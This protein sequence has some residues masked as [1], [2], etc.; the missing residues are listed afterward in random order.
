MLPM[1]RSYN[2]QSWPHSWWGC[3]GSK[4]WPCVFS[5]IV[6]LS[7]ELLCF[8][9]GSPCFL[10]CLFNFTCLAIDASGGYLKAVQTPTTAAV[11]HGWGDRQWLISYNIERRSGFS[12]KIIWPQGETPNMILNMLTLYNIIQCRLSLSS[13]LSYIPEHNIMEN[14]REE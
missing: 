2:W 8:L 12:Q 5:C 10:N 7:V 6:G 9:P 13:L 4:N 11:R 1:V 14:S 3:C